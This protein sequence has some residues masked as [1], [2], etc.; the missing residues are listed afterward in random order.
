M[1]IRVLGCSGGIGGHHLRTTSFLVDHDILIDAGTGVGDLSIAELAQIDHVF[2]THSHLDHVV[3]LAFMVDA[4]G[5]MRDKPLTVHATEATIQI[6]SGNNA[7]KELELTK[8][9]TTLGKPKIQVAVIARRPQGYFITHV[10]GE[11]FPVI[12]GISVGA[13]AQAL[14]DYDVIELAGIK[15]TFFLKH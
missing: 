9:L 8:G 6:L 14:K 13:Q 4:V 7:G 3:S 11:T 15:M 2:I 10:E 12:N 5:D 1:K